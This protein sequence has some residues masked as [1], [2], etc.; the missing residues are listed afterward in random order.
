MNRA[1]LPPLASSSIGASSA[2]PRALVATVSRRG[3]VTHAG[4]A[5]MASSS[6]C[7][8]GRTVVAVARRRDR[9]PKNPGEGV[10]W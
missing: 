7:N 2:R 1:L 6:R 10:D 8:D 9:S 4:A 5:V 3:F